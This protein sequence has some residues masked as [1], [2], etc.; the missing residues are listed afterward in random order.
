MAIITLFHIGGS[1]RTDLREF[2]FQFFTL[3]PRFGKQ[4]T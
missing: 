1:D 4:I 3:V 2:C